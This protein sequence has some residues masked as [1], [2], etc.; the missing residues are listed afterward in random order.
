M[1]TTLLGTGVFILPQMTIDKAQSGALVAWILL[2]LA[3]IPVAL[4][5][6][7]LASVFPHAAGPAYFVEKAFGRTAGRTIGLIFLL[8]VP[9][10]APAAILM[11]FQ[12]VNALI[13][14]SGWSKV[15]VEILVIFGLFLINLRG[16]QVSAKLQFGLTL[17][18][19]AVVVVLFG[20][21]SFQPD[22]LT[23]LASHGMPEMPTVMIAAGIAFWSFLGIEA[24]THLADDFHRPQQDMIPAMMMGTVL[25]GVIYVACTLL[26]LLV[27]TDKSVAMIGVFDQLLGGYGAQ[28]IGILG[29]ASGLATVNVYAASAARLVWS[30][31]CEGILPRFFAVKNAHGVPIR[32]LAALLSVMASVIVLTYISGQELEHLIAWSNS[33][34]VVIYLM[35]M[36]AAAKLLP[37]H[38]WPLVALGCVFCVVLAFALGA[39]MSYVLVLILVVAPFLWW[40]KSH[41]IRKQSLA[42]PESLL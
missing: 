32:A 42:I 15:G 27:P 7:R 33:V 26:L 40:Q 6:G 28:V 30:F 38:N 22:Q 25:V 37:R 23:I 41:I 1:A 11:T 39:S 19:V 14:I 8:V 24:M 36:L 31:S 16:I 4:V 17:C 21:N 10:G 34:F 13:P 5:F 9:M 3:I 20:A 12:F 35:A 18:I 29:I 2:T